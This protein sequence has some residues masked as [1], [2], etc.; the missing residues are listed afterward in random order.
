MAFDFRSVIDH[1]WNNM[2][3]YNYKLMRSVLLE[4]MSSLWFMVY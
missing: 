3:S 2:V 4:T 1:V